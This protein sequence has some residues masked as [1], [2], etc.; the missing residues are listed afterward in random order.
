MPNV[1][2]A[3]PGKSRDFVA[4]PQSAT[5]SKAVPASVHVATKTAPPRAAAPARPTSQPASP[6]PSPRATTAPRPASPPAR[7]TAKPNETARPAATAK[8]AAAA[9]P[10]PAQGPVKAQAPAPVPPQ[11]HKVEEPVTTA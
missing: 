6:A 1:P 3:A 7:P 10:A 2:S 11:K 9:K 8:A 4:Q 5:H